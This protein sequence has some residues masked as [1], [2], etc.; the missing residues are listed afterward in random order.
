M[1]RDHYLDTSRITTDPNVLKIFKLIRHHGGV[2]RFVGGAVRDALAG[3]KVANIDLSTDLSPDELAEACEEA[4]IRTAPI[5]LKIDTLGVAAGSA[6]LEISSLKKQVTDGRGHT[7]VEF[8]DNWE[9]D[10]SCRDLTINAVY[11]DEDGNVFDYYNGIEDLENGV[12]RFIGDPNR[13]IREDYV[14]ILRFFRFYSL[15]GRAPIDAKS[16]KACRDNANGLKKLPVER[17]RDEVVK[18]LLTPNAAQTLKIMFENEILS[19]W[20][21]DSP[22][23]EDLDKLIKL[24][25]KYGF[26]PDPIRR[27]F[28]LSRPDKTLAE[29]TAV[30]MKLTKHQ[31]ENLIRLAEEKC[32]F[33][34]L[35]RPLELKQSVYRLG[36]ELCLSLL[37]LEEAGNHGCEKDLSAVIQ[38][39]RETT[40]PIFPISGKDIIHHGITGNA[41]IGAAR[42]YLEQVWYDSGFKLNRDELLAKIKP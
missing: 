24:E 11:A 19:T 27:G 39:V 16:L 17:I 42:E 38:A 8:T 4:G 26:S 22:Y 6:L 33:A 9:A 41:K 15:F 20:M 36:K 37:L 3:Q 35:N 28:I 25:A 2:V 23:L 32:G 5:G 40:V 10:A 21:M 14:R 30:R 18:I 12:I 1:I 7:E 13:Q 31:K 34:D 29:N